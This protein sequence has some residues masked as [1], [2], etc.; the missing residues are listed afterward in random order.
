MSEEKDPSETISEALSQLNDF[1]KANQALVILKAIGWIDDYDDDRVDGK[2]LDDYEN[3]SKAEECDTWSQFYWE[4]EE[5][6]RGEFLASVG[7]A[8]LNKN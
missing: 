7:K 1:D 4:L 5:S 3:H 6:E 2:I 8:Y